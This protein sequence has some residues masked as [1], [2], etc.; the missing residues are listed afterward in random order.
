M[1]EKILDI[2]KSTPIPLQSKQIVERLREVHNIE[3]KQFQVRDLLWGDLKENIIYRGKP[4][5][6]YKLRV[7]YRVTNVKFTKRVNYIE[8]KEQPLCSIQISHLKSEII[9]F[10][11]KAHSKYHHNDEH[12]ILFFL[13]AWEDI[14]V[15][16]EDAWTIFYNYVTKLK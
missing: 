11:N 14:L 16:N 1:K 2:L 13:E 5:Y 4:Y 9:F 6:D 7:N 10:I 15:Y 3:I 12:L 8:N